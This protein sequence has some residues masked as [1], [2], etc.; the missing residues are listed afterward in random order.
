M[1]FITVHVYIYPPCHKTVKGINLFGNKLK[2]S[3]FAEH[4]QIYL[5]SDF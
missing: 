1:P 2:L 3:Q 4:V 5:V